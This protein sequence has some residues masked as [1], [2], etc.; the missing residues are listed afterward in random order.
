MGDLVIHK[1]FG[2]GKITKIKEKKLSIVFSDSIER[3]FEKA[4]FYSG[5]LLIERK[6]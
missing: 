4:I 1:L 6:Q 2:E 5:Q 3:H